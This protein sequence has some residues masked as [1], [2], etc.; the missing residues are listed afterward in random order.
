MVG[1]NNL[2]EDDMVGM[3]KDSGGRL[4]KLSLQ[5]VMLENPAA[6]NALL[7]YP[8]IYAMMVEVIEDVTT[9]FAVDT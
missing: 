2:T 8:Q 1:I 5:V 3:V 6:R 9:K 4:A 7:S